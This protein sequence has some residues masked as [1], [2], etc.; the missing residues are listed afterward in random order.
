M[1][2]EESPGTAGDR[3]V[4]VDL[5]EAV[6]AVLYCS[7]DRS[8]IVAGFVGTVEALKKPEKMVPERYSHTRQA[9]RKLMSMTDGCHRH[10][11]DRGIV[12]I[13]GPPSFKSVLG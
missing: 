7:P 8:V 5:G 6:G 3:A 12:N 4:V 9:A 11:L 1:S 2:K 10:W 13:D